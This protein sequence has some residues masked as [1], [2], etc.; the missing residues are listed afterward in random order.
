MLERDDRADPKIEQHKEKLLEVAQQKQARGEITRDQ[1]DAIEYEVSN[2]ETRDF[3]PFLYLIVRER[4]KGRTQ[5]VIVQ[6][7]ANPNSEEYIIEDLDSSEFE[8][9]RTSI[10]LSGGL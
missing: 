8:M 10:E 5:D 4:V 1:Y 3:A 6:K 9:I 7:R 2:S